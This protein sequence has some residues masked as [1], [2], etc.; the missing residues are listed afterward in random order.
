[1]ST[2]AL[3]FHP[4]KTCL[5]HSRD[6]KP[7]PQGKHKRQACHGWSRKKKA[8]KFMFLCYLSASYQNYRSTGP[9]A[10]A[11]S[12]STTHTAAQKAVGPASEQ[13]HGRRRAP[14]AAVRRRGASPWRQARQHEAECPT[15]ISSLGPLLR[16]LPDYIHAIPD[17]SHESS[18]QKN[19]DC[20]YLLLLHPFLIIL[21]SRNKKEQVGPCTNRQATASQQ[22]GYT[23]TAPVLSTSGSPEW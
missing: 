5:F 15:N 11:W 20:F 14:T 2:P 19:F 10:V 13:Q 8:S 6:V 12:N 4:K 18:V 22:S 1:M 3:F 21:S 7:A 23:Q 16:R 17:C 9:L